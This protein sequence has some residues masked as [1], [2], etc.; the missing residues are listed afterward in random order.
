MLIIGVGGG[1]DVLTSIV[2]GQRPIVGVE[3]NH[4]ILNLLN[5]RYADYSGNLGQQ[6]GVTLVHDEARSYV[7]RSK[8][9]FDIIQASLIDTWAATAAGDYTLSENGLYT[10][11][12]WTTFLDRLKPD[13]ILTMSRWESLRMASLATT[14]LLEMGIENPRQHIMIVKTRDYLTGRT[15]S[16]SNIMVSRRPFPAE[17]ISRILSASKESDFILVLAPNFSDS[18]QF[19]AVADP[20]QY[21]KL[22]QDYPVNVWP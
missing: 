15:P 20:M 3:I 17:E 6:P 7:A 16:L 8:E 5:F 10:K 4:D 9:K 19:T 21:P 12:A 18:P 13:G 14:T 2:F 22:I 11:E 1:R